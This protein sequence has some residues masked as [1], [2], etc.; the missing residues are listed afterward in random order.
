MTEYVTVDQAK[1][2]AKNLL[3]P[4]AGG[5]GSGSDNPNLAE[6]AWN[7]LLDSLSVGSVDNRH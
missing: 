6:A 7:D 4:S 3:N 1:E 2:I 5:G